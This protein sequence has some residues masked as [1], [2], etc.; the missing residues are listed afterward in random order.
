[1]PNLS[2]GNLSF[3]TIFGELKTVGSRQLLKKTLNY[4]DAIDCEEPCGHLYLDRR[5]S[6]VVKDLETLDLLKERKKFQLTPVFI[7]DQ[8]KE[9]AGGEG[10][11]GSE[12][13]CTSILIRDLV[14]V[15]VTSEK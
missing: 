2:N 7:M 12:D 6:E 4:F 14:T 3:P 11:S 8:G 9:V 10:G 13:G 5:K 15:D 1:M